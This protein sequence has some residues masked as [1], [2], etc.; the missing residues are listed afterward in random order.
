[1]ARGVVVG[2]KASKY[3]SNAKNKPGKIVQSPL[4][5]TEKKKEQLKP[6]ILYEKIDSIFIFTW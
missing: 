6:S 1:M 3:F 5:Y 2:F 4:D